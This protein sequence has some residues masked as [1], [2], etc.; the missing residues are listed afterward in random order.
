MSTAVSARVAI[1]TEA[2]RRSLSQQARTEVASV[3]TGMGTQSSMR[4]RLE[5]F[6]LLLTA[7]LML[8]LMASIATHF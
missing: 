8:L 1:D 2:P 4:M 6:V 7:L 3:S 5:S